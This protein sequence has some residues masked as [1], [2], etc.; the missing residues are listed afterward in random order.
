VPSEKLSLTAYAAH[1]VVAAPHDGREALV[2]VVVAREHEVDLVLVEHGHERR[3]L[4]LFVRWVVD[5]PAEHFILSR[6]RR[7]VQHDDLPGARILREYAI[8]PVGLDLERLG[9]PTEGLRR[10][11]DDDQ[12]AIENVVEVLRVRHVISRQRED[13]V[14]ERFVALHACR[15]RGCR[16][17]AGTGRGRSTGLESSRKTVHCAASSPSLTRSPVFTHEARGLCRR[18]ADNRGHLGLGPAA[19]IAAIVAERDERE[20]GA[21]IFERRRAEGERL[22]PSAGTGL[23]AA[24]AEVVERIGRQSVE[25]HLVHPSDAVAHELRCP[26]GVLP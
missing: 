17:Q 26:D 16:W 7:V 12:V 5:D 4:A 3:V 8:E 19:V 21:A 6:K 24:G 23:H 1:R 13:L 18:L 22:A 14:V 2:E 10:E 25:R 11:R 9:A 20:R 15:R